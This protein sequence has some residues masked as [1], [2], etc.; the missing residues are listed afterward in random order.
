MHLATMQCTKILA[1]KMHGGSLWL[2]KEYPIHVDDIH[3][4]IGLLAGVNVVATTF[5]G[6]TKRAK[7]E[8]DKN[9]YEKYNIK[10][11]GRGV[12]IDLIT[13]DEIKFSYYII[14]RK[15]MRLFSMNECTL[16][17]ILAMEHF[18]QGEV[19]NWST[20]VLNVLFEVYE[21]IYKRSM[22]FIFGYILMNLEMWKWQP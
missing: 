19:L 12:R 11:G 3:H 15:T 22:N 18:C 7:K 20:F 4:L 9:Y 8:G 10:H 16:D 13:K 1:N 21:D 2:E 14:A 6:G 5:Q 17:T